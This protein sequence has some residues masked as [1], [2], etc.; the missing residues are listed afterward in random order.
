MGDIYKWICV[1][2]HCVD[3]FNFCCYYNIQP[4]MCLLNISK[5]PHTIYKHIFALCAS[6]NVTAGTMCPAA[7][8][9]HSLLLQHTTTY[10]I[11]EYRTKHFITF[12]IH[13]SLCASQNVTAGYIPPPIFVYMEYVLATTTLWLY[14]IEPKT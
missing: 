4:P 12:Q 13:P 2:T 9:R 1:C 3:V 11:M 14:N 6:Q 10:V 7:H 5:K 8:I